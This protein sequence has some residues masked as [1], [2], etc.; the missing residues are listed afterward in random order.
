VSVHG[1][2]EK[3]LC[4]PDEAAS[5]VRPGDWVDYGLVTFPELID[6]ALAA[7]R[8]ELADVK[9]R[10]GLT[11]IP[12]ISVVESD[13]DRSVFT[14]NS[15]H[16]SA[17]ERKLHDRGLCSYIPM[18]FR[19]MPHFY[20]KHLTVDVA[21]IAV[22]RMDERGYFSTGISCAANRAIVDKAKRV[23]V[24]VNG[25]YPF[26][27]AGDEDLVHVSEVD[28]IVEGDHSPFPEPAAKPASDDDIR[29][30]R[31]IVPMI[32]SGAVLQFGIGGL[33]EIVGNMIAD[34]DIRDL[35]CH[36]EMFGTACLNLH[37]AGKIT[38]RRKRGH[39]GRS[40]WTLALGSNDVYEW[41]DGNKE[42]CAYPVDYVNDPAVIARNDDMV[43]IN[44]ALE[45][46]LYGQICAESVGARQISGSGGQLDFL[47]GA[48]YSEG[49]KGFVCLPSSY[50]D[51][52]GVLRSRITPSMTSGSVITDPRSQACY[53]VTE[54]GCAHLAGLSTWERAERL[55]S[56]AH[57]A[58]RDGL[59]RAAEEQKIWR[60]SNR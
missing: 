60:K 32:G 29:I 51:A 1:E 3:K 44:S 53:I 30:A 17:Y 58:F 5:Y 6:R 8:E 49:G 25:R 10:G 42:A 52:G 15:W 21:F 18:T 23:I 39:R 33:P 14:Y 59:I 13:T 31:Q 22:S 56:I 57:P 48:F 12:R 11:L 2:Y 50:R 26:A 19:Y 7:R 34:S 37:R 16:F 41:L 38:N 45:V 9:I 24:E 40:V 55:I 20:R 43:C 4:G 54:Y 27:C 35:G 36:T 47:T 28:G 46:D